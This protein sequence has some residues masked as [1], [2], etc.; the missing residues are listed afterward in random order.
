MTMARYPA[1]G[2]ARN[3]N[4]GGGIRWHAESRADGLRG[5]LSVLLQAY[6]TLQYITCLTGY[7]LARQQPPD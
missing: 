7:A 6:E 1:T 2:D 3:R 5:A 4:R